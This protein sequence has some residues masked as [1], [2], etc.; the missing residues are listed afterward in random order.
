MAH[1]IRVSLSLIPQLMFEGM[2][3]NTA[4]LDISLDGLSIR[5]GTC[6]RSEFQSLLSASPSP[7]C[8]HSPHPRQT[9]QNRGETAQR[10]GPQLASHESKL[11]GSWCYFI[12][13][14]GSVSSHCVRGPLSM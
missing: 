12:H 9:F 13:T 5:R 7:D 6:N 4:Y 10:V 3:G 2:R 14:P 11:L 1:R 8:S